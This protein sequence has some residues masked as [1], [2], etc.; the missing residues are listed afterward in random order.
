M[1]ELPPPKSPTPASDWSEVELTAAVVAYL[2]MLNAELDGRPYNKAQ[3]NRQLRGSELSRRSEG[4]VEFRMQNISAAL[5]ELKMPW[6]PGYKPAK[7]I[8]SAVKEKLIELLKLNG[9]D[10][11]SSYVPTT[12]PDL[13]SE[14]VAELR[15]RGLPKIPPGRLRPP[16]VV[17]DR[18]S[19]FRDPAVKAWVLEA[20]G[21]VC[22]GCGSVAPFVD[23]REQP[24]LELHHVMPLASHGSD[25]VTNAVALCPNCHRRCHSSKDKHEFKLELYERVPRLIIEVPEAIELD[26][27]T[28]IE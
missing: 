10:S 2:S 17:T 16:T 19:Y 4:S 11:L 8:G 23:D 3:I 20:A 7:N 25:T 14:R 5:Y 27:H 28:F 21:G 24:F 12:N 13:L 15:L 9:A 18:T 1:P 22:E 6:I 26:T